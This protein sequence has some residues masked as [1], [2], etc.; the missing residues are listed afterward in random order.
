MYQNIYHDR[1]SGIVHLWDD[2]KGYTNFPFERYAYVLDSRGD[3]VTMTGLR[4]K[5]VT[6]WSKELEKQNL[7]FEHDVPIYTRVLIDRYWNS[8]EPSKNNRVLF[9]DIEVA[10]EGKYSTPREASNTIT[11]IAYYDSI[12]QKYHCLIL[13][14]ENRLED[15]DGLKRF[16]TEQELLIHFLQ[17][18]QKIKPNIVTG[19]NCEFFD[20]PYLFNRLV[21]VLGDKWAKK[22]S[23]IGIVEDREFGKEYTVKI[24]GVSCLDYL[25]LYKNFTANQQPRYTLDFICN[26]ELGRGKVQY[27]GSL[28]D[29]F[30]NDIH[31]FIEY[32]ISDVELVVALDRKFDY[33]EIARGICHKGHVPYEDITMS[34]RFLDGALLTDCRRNNLITVRTERSETIEEPAEGAFVKLP[35][36][37]LYRYVYD[38]DLESEYP[39]NIKSLNISPETKWGRVIDYDVYDFVNKKDRL[40]QVQK[41][42]VKSLVD[43]WDNDKDHDEFEFNT[44]LDLKNFLDEH[45]LSISSAGILYNLDKKGLIP[46]ILTKWG[47]ERTDFRKTAKDY[48]N[49]GDIEKYKYYDRKQYVQKILLN[50]LYGVLLLNSFR[51]YDRE[52]GESVTYSGKSLIKFCQDVINWHYNKCI[53][54]M[55]SYEIEFDDGTVRV[56]NGSDIVNGEPVSNLYLSMEE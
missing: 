49:A 55:D 56:F 1:N 14:V 25:M 5:K 48:H 10:K 35:A 22:L 27:E 3:Y 39:N 50:S 13:D 16:G 6:S 28:D 47:E 38:L 4:C 2:E 12:D 44:W 9:F 23:P 53:S 24:A 20:I 30:R 32:N 37:G 29:L 26:A 51:F 43:R 34:S 54:T 33:I 18:W 46:T 17:C 42:N 36:P 19:W 31:K 7:V 45:N 52:N 11:S 15:R 21:N 41:I 8:D 40:Y